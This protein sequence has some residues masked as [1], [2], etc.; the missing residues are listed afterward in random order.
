MNQ[1]DKD[2][3]I[4]WMVY[5]QASA[6][7]GVND[8]KERMEKFDVVYAIEQSGSCIQGQYIFTY[9]ENILERISEGIDMKEVLEATKKSLSEKLLND[10]FSSTSTNSL[11]NAVQ[12][13]Q[14][15]AASRL[16]EKIQSFLDNIQSAD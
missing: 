1:A 7:A 16:L 11:A 9:F 14:R 6:K 4:R 12:E 15:K 8:F 2:A 13:F 5:E 10:Y 3:L